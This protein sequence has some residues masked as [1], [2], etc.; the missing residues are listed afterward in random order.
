MSSWAERPGYGALKSRHDIPLLGLFLHCQNSLFDEQSAELTNNSAIYKGNYH[1]QK[2]LKE[3]KIQVLKAL[4]S[5]V[6]DF[7]RHCIVTAD[8]H[9]ASGVSHSEYFSAFFLQAHG[10]WLRLRLC[11]LCPCPSPQSHPAVSL[12][13]GGWNSIQDSLSLLLSLIYAQYLQK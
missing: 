12:L 8:F 9:E 13:S 2:E 4:L 1:L 11:F 5:V 7:V 3:K 10:V 6:T